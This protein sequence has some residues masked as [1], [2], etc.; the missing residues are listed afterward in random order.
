MALLFSCSSSPVPSENTNS[1]KAI[2]PSGIR[3]LPGRC[4]DGL[5]VNARTDKANPKIPTATSTQGPK[6]GLKFHLGSRSAKMYLSRPILSEACGMF[7]QH[8]M[9]LDPHGGAFEDQQP[10]R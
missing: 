5:A 8:S 3:P 10:K 4:A 9:R 6:R 1:Y 2:C 7:M